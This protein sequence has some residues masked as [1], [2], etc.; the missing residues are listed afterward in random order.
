M[1]GSWL[2]TQFS[3]ARWI[4]SPQLSDCLNGRSISLETSE[5]SPF[6]LFIGKELNP[7]LLNCCHLSG[8]KSTTNLSN[9]S[10]MNVILTIV[11]G[12][13]KLFTVWFSNL[14]FD[15]LISLDWLKGIVADEL[16][17]S[18]GILRIFPLLKKVKF[19]FLVFHLY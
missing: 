3:R 6:Y 18:F 5:K 4:K 10:T 19:V 11:F 7:N 12:N 9:H 14:R 2:S 8:F 17:F 1:Q 13:K 15:F 16:K